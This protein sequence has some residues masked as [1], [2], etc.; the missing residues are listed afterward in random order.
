M[1]RNIQLS[2]HI[3]GASTRMSVN[4][5]DILAHAAGPND[6]GYVWLR[7]QN[8]AIVVDHNIMELR[9]L[10]GGKPV[11]DSVSLVARAI[12]THVEM[13][14][15]HRSFAG[16]FERITKCAD[17]DGLCELAGLEVQGIEG[18]AQH[19]LQHSNKSVNA[20]AALYS[21]LRKLQPGLAEDMD[22]EVVRAFSLSAAA[23][24]H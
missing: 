14:A 21:Q 1:G 7:G 2:I 18:A 9:C 22:L 16:V 4:S 10:L 8:G 20:A 6:K 12:L 13:G 17:V 5:D 11:S 15:L 24:A 3:N 19:A 23:E